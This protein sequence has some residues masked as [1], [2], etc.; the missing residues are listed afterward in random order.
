[1][2]NVARLSPRLTHLNLLGVRVELLVIHASCPADLSLDSA[3]VPDCLHDVAR[4]GLALCAD[5]GGALADAAEGLAEVAAAADKGNLEGVLVDVVL[6]VGGGE[7]LGLVDVVDVERLEDLRLDE[8]ADTALG[9]VA[10][11]R[12]ACR[13]GAMGYAC[14]YVRV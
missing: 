13:D 12:G 4:A 1:M 10:G 2:R 11:A 7:D 9:L 8:V 5:H 3:L 14:V 6:V